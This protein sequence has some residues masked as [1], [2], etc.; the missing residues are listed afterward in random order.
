M[1]KQTTQIIDL[2]TRA[3]YAIA[4]GP[5]LPGLSQLDLIRTMVLSI[6]NRGMSEALACTAA[7]GLSIDEMLDRAVLLGEMSLRETAVVSDKI[8]ETLR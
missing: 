6:Y 5:R 4:N 8:A 2:S 7:D 1:D 3:L